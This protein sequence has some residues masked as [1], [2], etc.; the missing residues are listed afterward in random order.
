M[1][2]FGGLATPLAVLAAF[3][4]VAYLSLFPGACAIGLAW[5]ARAFG[6][7]AALMTPPLWVATELGR[8]YVWDGFPWVLLG[9]S[10]VTWLPIAQL[11]S[12]TGVYGLSGLLALTAAAAAYVVVDTGRRRWVVV[13]ATLAWRGAVRG[14]GTVANQRRRAV[15]VG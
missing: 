10:Q 7:A 3:L 9:Y 1:T 8:Q 12:I 5:L 6:P 4:L 2:T 15:G 11:A 14:V 13:A